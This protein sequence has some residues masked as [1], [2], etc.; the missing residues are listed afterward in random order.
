[1]FQSAKDGDFVVNMPSLEI[2]ATP[3]RDGVNGIVKATKPLIYH[4]V[5]IDDFWF[6]LEHGRIIHYGARIG[7][8]TLK[9]IVETDEGSHYL[10]EIALVD[11]DSKI[12]QSGIVFKTTLYDENASCHL[13]IGSGFPECFVN[14]LGKSKEELKL[15]GMNDSSTHVD[16]MIGSRDLEIIATL[17][18][19]S[20]VMLMKHGKLIF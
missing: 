6:Q 18:D 8:E 19:G 12:N 1:M 3:K 16:F 4:N 17:E 10:G 11:F 9:Q 5:V 20:E 13:A 15:L 14:G 2:F 7:E